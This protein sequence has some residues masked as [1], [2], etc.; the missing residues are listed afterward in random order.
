[1]ILQLASPLPSE[2]PRGSASQPHRKDVARRQLGELERKGTTSHRVKPL[3]E[4]LPV[5]DLH[6]ETIRIKLAETKPEGAWWRNFLECGVG[7]VW[8]C[9]AECERCKV[10][11]ASCGLKWCP[12][13]SWKRTDE[14]RRMLAAITRGMSTCKHVV[15]TQRNFP[16]LNHAKIKQSRANLMKLRRQHVFGNV[17]GGCATLEF[18]NEGR[19][20]HMHWHL[21]LDTDAINPAALAIA[22]GKLVEQEYAIVKVL[23][24]KGESY[25]A[26][27]CK[28]VVSPAELASWKPLEIRQ[29]VDAL[30]GTRTFT[31]F[32]SFIAAREA[33]KPEIKASKPAPAI[34]QCG[35]SQKFI[36]P[37]ESSVHAMFAKQFR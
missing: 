6:T 15:L 24:V 21:L 4:L 8:S 14:R 27:V 35:C 22:W 7:V 2:T 23:A 1:M 29:F 12:R 30:R 37:T 18:T 5:G 26:E 28:Y 10:L 17:R 20:W 25:V 36:G 16:V 3:P 9:C 33:A 13:C 19:G 31:V 11:K 32:G 34:C